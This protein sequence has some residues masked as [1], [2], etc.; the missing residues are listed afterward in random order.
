V[1][2]FLVDIAA[3]RSGATGVNTV[4][5][6]VGGLAGTVCAAVAPAIASNPGFYVSEV[7]GIVTDTIAVAVRGASQDF[8]GYARK[9]T[10]C[11]DAYQDVEETNSR[12]FLGSQGD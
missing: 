8:Q 7:L 1:S 9:L 4:S 12:L 3:L 10:S 11:A 5:S 2:G 6:E